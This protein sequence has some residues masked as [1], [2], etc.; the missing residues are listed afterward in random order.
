MIRTFIIASVSYNPN[1]YS[2]ASLPV[3]HMIPQ[4]AMGGGNIWKPLSE[5]DPRD[6]RCPFFPNFTII[7]HVVH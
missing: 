4:P 7:P 6:R 3:P 5:P 1:D 2:Q